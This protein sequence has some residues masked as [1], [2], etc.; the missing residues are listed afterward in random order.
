MNLNLS[1]YQFYL[2]KILIWI[3]YIFFFLNLLV[4]NISTEII[5]G[6]LFSGVLIQMSV[7]AFINSWYYKG[8]PML[9]DWFRLSTFLYIILNFFSIVKHLKTQNN[10]NG[11]IINDYMIMPSLL[12]IFIGFCGLFVAEFIFKLVKMTKT[13]KLVKTKYKFRSVQFYYIFVVFILVTHIYLMLTG[14]IG[15][16]T[17]Q[18]NTTSSLSFLFQSLLLISPF[19]LGVFSIMKYIFN[20]NDTKFNYIFIIFFII[21]II[22]G[23]LSG[24][25]ESIIVPIIIVAIPYLLSG[26]KVPKKMLVI[27]S[28]CFLFIYPINNSFREI[29][30]K[31]PNLPREKAFGLALTKTVDINF[32]DNLKNS[33]NNYSDRLSLYPYLVY[34]IEHEENWSVYKSMDRYVYLPVSWIVPRFILPDKPKSENGGLLNEMI[35]GRDVGPNSLTV[36]SYG[37]AFFEGGYFYVFILFLFFGLVISYFENILGLSSFFGILIYTQLLVLLLKVETDIYFL[38]SNIFQMLLINYILFK[39]FIKVRKYR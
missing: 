4:T 24:M 16:G 19:L 25:K 8:K 35:Y 20:F 1:I 7:I 33:T 23:F 38:I 28:I 9:L 34:A 39:L 32:S 2:I 36:T 37:W 6:V 11:Y 21:Q 18:E 13:K 5:G 12:A 26:R 29:L 14:Q 22:S 3:L 27:G 31:Y 17:L 15:Y 30:N 10:F